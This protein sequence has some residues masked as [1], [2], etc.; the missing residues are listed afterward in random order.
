M[1]VREVRGHHPDSRT[2]FPWADMVM[3]NGIERELEPEESDRHS[4]LE[5][6]NRAVGLR[7][8]IS[9]MN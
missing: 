3:E 7:L 4:C 6:V 8:L 9:F 2:S 1:E 5:R